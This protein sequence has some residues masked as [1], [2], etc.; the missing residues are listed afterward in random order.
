M[1]PL[2]LQLNPILIP[3]IN[4]HL[5]EQYEVH[6]YFEMTDQSGWHCNSMAPA[7]KP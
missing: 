6:K 2:V 1:K 5:A 3:A 7:F 4:Q